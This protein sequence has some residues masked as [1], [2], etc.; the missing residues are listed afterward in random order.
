MHTVAIMTKT[1]KIVG[2]ARSLSERRKEG[3]VVM[4]HPFRR[5]TLDIRSARSGA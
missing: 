4:D 3:F 5:E 2:H 1:S